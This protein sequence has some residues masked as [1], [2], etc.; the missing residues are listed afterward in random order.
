MSDLASREL[1]LKIE[2]LFL[3]NSGNSLE[4]KAAAGFVVAAYTGQSLLISTRVAEGAGDEQVDAVI[5]L[6]LGRLLQA[7]VDASHQRFISHDE[8]V[9]MHVSDAGKIFAILND[10]KVLFHGLLGNFKDF[11]CTAKDE[12]CST[13]CYLK[14]LFDARHL[15]VDV[16][17]DVL[18]TKLAPNFDV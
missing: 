2:H 17:V 7:V 3:V 4:C 11:S 10:L 1:R 15:G 9:A 16:A 6:V 14:E 18:V 12:L 5:S 8:A 13:I